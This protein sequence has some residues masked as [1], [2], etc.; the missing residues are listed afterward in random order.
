[1]KE[2]ELK[3]FEQNLREEERSANTISKYVRDVSR[4]LDFAGDSE[5]SR[6]LIIDWKQSLIGAGY[7]PRSVNSMLAAVN[8]FL[9]YIG[10]R[11]L[12]VRSMRIQKQTYRQE[13]DELTKEEY[14]RLIQAASGRPKLQLIIQTIC[15]TG[16]RVSELSS[17]TVEAVRYGEVVISNKGK[18]REIMIPSRLRQLILDYAVR[19]DITHGVVFRNIYG[20]PV[21]RSTIWHGMK[22]LCTR[23]GID[24]HKAYP[25]NLRKLFARE[26]YAAD[27]D[28]SKL[29]DVLGH[30][31]IETTRIYIMGTGKEHREQIDRLGL[32]I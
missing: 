9:L 2:L 16:I 20:E 10:R 6:E 15:S 24:P 19:N 8:S 12:M 13:S 7:R 14:F 28:I 21:D 22:S 30:S 31:S 23:A 29:A 17:F 4:F 18:I 27:K 25:H 1:M 26:F 32:T 11:D 3:R 5:L